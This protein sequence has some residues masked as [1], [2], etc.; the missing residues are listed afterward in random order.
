MCKQ[1]TNPPSKLTGFLYQSFMGYVCLAMDTD[2]SDDRTVLTLEQIK[3]LDI[4][5]YELPN[6]DNEKYQHIY[7]DYPNQ[8]KEDQTLTNNQ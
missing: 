1:K 2:K 3:R 8:N 6:F 7:G 5:L 4:A